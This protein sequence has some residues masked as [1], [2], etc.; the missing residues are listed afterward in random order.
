[1]T[2]DAQKATG[3]ADIE[4]LDPRPGKRAV[5]L[6]ITPRP[7][8]LMARESG[9]CSDFT[10]RNRRPLAGEEGCRLDRLRPRLNVFPRPLTR[11]T[12]VRRQP[13]FSNR[14]RR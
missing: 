5:T 11:G 6:R 4:M 1:M 2:A 9:K 14:E 10:D 7:I 13:L 8:S 12:V 3:K